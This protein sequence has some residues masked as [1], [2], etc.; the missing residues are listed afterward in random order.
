MPK[1]VNTVINTNI[2][3]NWSLPDIAEILGV[4]YD[5][6]RFDGVVYRTK[7]P[8]FT[9]IFLKNGN[10]VANIT[11]TEYIDVWRNEFIRLL[12]IMDIHIPDPE[13]IH[14]KIQNIVAAADLGQGV[15]LESVALLLGLEN[16]EYNPESFAGMNF[17]IPE[18]NATLIIFSSGKVNIV[19][20]KK[21]GDAK[22]AFERLKMI[23]DV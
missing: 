23:L 21:D 1:V 22:L 3:I 8:K 5:K 18:L 12:G 14:T 16:V 7:E 11:N 17:R 9:T 6:G 2:G 20:T 19:G 13:K 10:V 4:E 15:N